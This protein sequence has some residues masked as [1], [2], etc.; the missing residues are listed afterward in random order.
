MRLGVVKGRCPS[1][2]AFG[3]QSFGLSNIRTR[4]I[5]TYTERDGCP[6]Q[7]VLGAKRL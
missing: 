6:L 2:R 1:L 3:G 7:R 5:L 4:V